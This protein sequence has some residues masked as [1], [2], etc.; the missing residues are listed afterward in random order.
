M[1]RKINPTG[2]RVGVTQDWKSTWYAE[3][4]RYANFLI[5]DD[6]IRRYLHRALRSAGVEVILIERSI[7]AMKIIIRVSRPGVVIGRK[8][9]GLSEI[10]SK[11]SKITKHDIDLQIEEVKN[12]EASAPIVAEAVAM[13]IERRI[14][15]K[16]AINMAAEKAM[17]AGSKGIKLEISGTVNGPNSIAMNDIVTKGAV[18]TQTLR[19]NIDFAKGIAFTRGGTIGIKVWVYKGEVED[20]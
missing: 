6:K 20:R 15:A 5:E 13:Q 3:G 12:P 11:I 10:R 9:A 17:N 19:A 4:D 1:S 7:K 16:R 18:P 14:S 8:G 2:L